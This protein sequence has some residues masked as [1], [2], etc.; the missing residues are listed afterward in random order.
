MS[1]TL[2]RQRRVRLDGDSDLPLK[3]TPATEADGLAPSARLRDPRRS[4]RVTALETSD[5][6]V[7]SS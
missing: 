5:V 4:P 2:S 1:T 6:L 3:H 7:E